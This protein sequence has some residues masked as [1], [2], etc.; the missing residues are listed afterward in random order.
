M[1]KVDLRVFIDEIYIKAID[2]MVEEGHGTNR[3]QVVR[4]IVQEWLREKGR[5]R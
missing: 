1:P 5:V 2:K 4:M 3:S